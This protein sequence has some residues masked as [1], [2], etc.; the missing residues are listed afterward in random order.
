MSVSDNGRNRRR[1]RLLRA[2]GFA[3]SVAAVAALVTGTSYG[4]FS[5]T[6]PTRSN[7]FTA[8]KV[9]QTNDLTGACSVSN[10][11]P[12]GTPTSCTLKTTYAGNA[13]GYLGLD[14]LI[15]TQAGAGGTKLYN[16]SDSANDLQISIAS[17]S[18]TVAAYT[19]PTTPTACPG[20]PPAGSTC[21]RAYHQFV[22]TTPF[23]GSSPQ[24]TFTTTLSLPTTSTTGYQGGTAQII[25]TAHATQ[26]GN[27]VH[28]GCTAGQACNTVSWN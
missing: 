12:N 13:P 3:L 4:F 17:T 5:T 18:P 27:N 11:L 20:T 2:A 7:T 1:S 15:E 21:Y 25:L 14:V 22:S 8:G 16:P 28:S 9:T 10:M 6:S 23:T 26:S 19:I 24:V